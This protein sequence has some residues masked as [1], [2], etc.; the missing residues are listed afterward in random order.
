M[1]KEVQIR[2]IVS[3]NVFSTERSPLLKNSLEAKKF[4]EE[5]FTIQEA[6]VFQFQCVCRFV[7]YPLS[8]IVAAVVEYDRLTVPI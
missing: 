4:L 1:E 7:D 3:Q 8:F 5:E 2:K 6:S